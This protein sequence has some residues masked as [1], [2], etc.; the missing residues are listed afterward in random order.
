M[1]VKSKMARI[2]YSV[3]VPVMMLKRLLSIEKLLRQVTVCVI[4]LEG[5]ECKGKDE[6]LY[7]LKNFLVPMIIAEH[8]QRTQGMSNRKDYDE[9]LVFEISEHGFKFLSDDEVTKAFFAKTETF[10]KIVFTGS[11]PVKEFENTQY[12]RHQTQGKLADDEELPV[13]LTEDYNSPTE[14]EAL[15]RS[16]YGIKFDNFPGGEAQYSVINCLLTGIEQYKELV[17]AKL[18]KALGSSE[19]KAY[20]VANEGEAQF[21]RFLPLLQQLNHR[22]LS[23]LCK[24]DEHSISRAERDELQATMTGLQVPNG[25]QATAL[26]TLD[27]VKFPADLVDP[28]NHGWMEYLSRGYYDRNCLFSRSEK[29]LGGNFGLA[30]GNNEVRRV[31]QKVIQQDGTLD[32]DEQEQRTANRELFKNATEANA[33]FTHHKPSRVSRFATASYDAASGAAQAVVPWVPQRVKNAGNAAMWLPTYVASAV[34]TRLQG[35]RRNPT[36]TVMSL[37]S[38]Y[39]SYDRYMGLLNNTLHYAGRFVGGTAYYAGAAASSV[40]DASGHRFSAAAHQVDDMTG[41]RISGA[42]NTGF[43]DVRNGAARMLGY[44]EAPVDVPVGAPPQTAPSCSCP[45]RNSPS[46]CTS[47]S[48]TSKYSSGS[49]STYLL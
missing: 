48:C 40:D 9:G 42:W 11:D 28:V 6:E 43:D 4:P 15:V 27:A 16:L 38:L 8:M 30:H 5:V 14:R 46:G 41:H 39:L 32:A 47:C 45:K 34:M 31:V 25:S 29:V 12:A 2:R 22:V 19:A 35:V 37:V 20:I 24:R 49:A 18:K 1:F 26:D 23:L 21:D 33:A 17:N 44:G 13:D 10:S 7:Y 36:A 3:L